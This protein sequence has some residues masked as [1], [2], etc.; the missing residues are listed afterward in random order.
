MKINLDDSLKQAQNIEQPN[1]DTGS[2][3]PRGAY[4][5]SDRRYEVQEIQERHR[6]M[7]RLSV[8]GCN[9]KE[10]AHQL[11]VSPQNVSDVLN[12]RLVKLHM[13]KLQ[14]VRDA[15]VAEA[16]IDLADMLPQAVEHYRDVLEGRVDPQDKTR[17]AGEVLD[18]AGVV[19]TAKIEAM[20]TTL[21]LTELQKIKERSL[22][23]ARERG[24]VV[25]VEVSD[26]V[27]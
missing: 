9:N 24:L 2:V 12:S 3:S 27:D 14:A 10:I 5:R 19:K 18:R 7:I 13:Q 26:G 25:D 1:W 22:A 6:E 23:A 11:G 16:Q 15:A 8:M 17:V 20:H 21:D 4:S